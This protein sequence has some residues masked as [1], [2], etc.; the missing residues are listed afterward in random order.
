MFDFIKKLFVIKITAV[1]AYDMANRPEYSK[2]EI[3]KKSNKLKKVIYKEIN[4]QAKNKAFLLLIGAGFINRKVNKSKTQTYGYVYSDSMELEF[5]NLI[6]ESV[7][8]EL[9][10]MGYTVIIKEKPA[11]NK[12]LDMVEISWAN[13][14]TIEFNKDLNNILK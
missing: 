3:I 11:N 5:F 8:V 4:E 12:Y 10:E 7:K 14:P 1:D 13:R 6:F 2:K 9:I